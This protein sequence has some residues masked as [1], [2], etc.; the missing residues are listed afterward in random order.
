MGKNV[1]EALKILLEALPEEVVTEVTSQLRQ[2]IITE[3]SRAKFTSEN[4]RKHASVKSKLLN[5]RLTEVY[6]EILEAEASRTGQSKTTVLKA[7]LAMYSS[8]D[9]N[10]KNHWLLESAKF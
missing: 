3:K 2:A 9:E 10:I 6:E 5:F 7:A 8:Q 4:E 1:T